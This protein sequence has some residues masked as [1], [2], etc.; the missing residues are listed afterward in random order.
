M[1]QTQLTGSNKAY[2]ENTQVDVFQTTRNGASGNAIFFSTGW[3]GGGLGTDIVYKQITRPFQVSD[4]GD[5]ALNLPDMGS[6][7]ELFVWPSECLMTFF[8]DKQTLNAGG[9][10]ERYQTRDPQTLAAAVEFLSRVRDAGGGRSI[11]NSPGEH[12]P[13]KGQ[14]YLGY[15]IDT[16][17]GCTSGGS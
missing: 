14:D 7:E 12:S 15:A 5:T 4:V 3:G 11:D 13:T 17:R 8:P 1:N 16:L 6:R 9:Q 10:W 2:Y